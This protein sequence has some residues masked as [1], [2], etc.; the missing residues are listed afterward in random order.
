MEKRVLIVLLL[1]ITKLTIAQKTDWSNWTIATNCFKGLEVRFRIS[2]NT[3]WEPDKTHDYPRYHYEFEIKNNYNTQCA[4]SWAFDVEGTHLNKATDRAT[5]K[6]GE[7][8]TTWYLR[9]KPTTGRMEWW[10]EM[11]CFSFPDGFD[12]WATNPVEGQAYFAE[13]DNGTPNYKV[14]GKT[15]KQD[16]NTKEEAQKYNTTNN[17]PPIKIVPIN[18]D[19]KSS[20]NSKSSLNK[21]SSEQFLTAIKSEIKARAVGKNLEIF[22]KNIIA[23]YKKQGYTYLG[24]EDE[25]SM[26]G[27]ALGSKLAKFKEFDIK[28]AINK[29]VVGFGLD[30]NEGYEKQETEYKSNNI[31][32]IDNDE[33]FINLNGGA[34]DYDK[35][36]LAARY[37]ITYNYFIKE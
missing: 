36:V 29:L 19:G 2:Q 31:G 10:F 37:D 13:C 30:F 15:E 9:G 3:V 33:F 25:V 8:T 21:M 28:I 5:I 23:L 4:V 32:T 27:K 7:S 18:N 14:K 17:N 35:N 16:G 1:L 12:Y 24:I 11:L 22:S 34:S 26:S 6:P 20:T